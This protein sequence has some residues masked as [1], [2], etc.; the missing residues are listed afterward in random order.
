MILPASPQSRR[1][2]AWSARW[3]RH[4]EAAAG[5]LN[6]LIAVLRSRTASDSGLS[7]SLENRG[8]LF[9]APPQEMISARSRLRCRGRLR[10]EGKASL[11]RMTA[12]RLIRRQPMR[13]AGRLSVG[14]GASRPGIPRRIC[15]DSDFSGAMRYS[16]GKGNEN[17]KSDCP[18]I[19]AGNA[20]AE[21]IAAFS[22][23][24]AKA[25]GAPTL[26]KRGKIRA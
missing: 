25:A 18:G 26:V 11:A 19:G 15:P 22:C 21:R 2:G 3:R 24:K 17:F 13:T 14:F 1:A 23:G 12:F 8:R 20:P 10:L 7:R 9:I 16:R 5:P 6:S 4:S